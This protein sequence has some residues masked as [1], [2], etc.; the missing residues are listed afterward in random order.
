MQI[1][2]IPISR[3]KPNLNQP[4]KFLDKSKLQEL[5]DS[6]KKRG[7]LEEI[8]VRPKDEYFEIVLGER[9]WRA[10]KLLGLKIVKA[11]VQDLSDDEAFE[12]SL[13]ENIQRENLL[14]IEEA[15]AYETL[16]KRG[17]SHEKIANKVNKTRTYI[18]QKLRLLRLPF[19]V[20]L[21]L[22]DGTLTE[23]HAR[24]LLRL[25]SI[26]GR[27]QNLEKSASWAILIKGSFK[28]WVEYYQD[29][30]AWSVVQ[31]EKLNV[32]KLKERIDKFYFDVISAAL[33]IRHPLNKEEEGKMPEV[34]KKVTDGLPLSSGENHLFNRW[35]ENGL[36]EKLGL[37][38][39]TLTDEDR[40]F[41]LDYIEKYQLIRSG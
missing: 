28:D 3:I 17:L 32:R 1:R 35:F 36:R 37:C 13:I 39:E 16:A 38:R 26:V 10:C 15:E 19:T 23:G 9:R 34:L 7:L 2:N 40:K 11:K 6:I 22:K 27:H 20:K 8:L 30:F 24:Q 4:R 18:T 33:G 14:P 41:F 21:L 29:Y 5:A 25:E 12:L 31:R